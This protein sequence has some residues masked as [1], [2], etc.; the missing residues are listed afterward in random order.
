MLELVADASLKT[1]EG[2][3]SDVLVLTLRHYIQQSKNRGKSQIETRFFNHLS[4]FVEVT[5]PKITRFQNKN[6]NVLTFICLY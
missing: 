1:K 6:K 2:T 4:Y 5:L 3:V